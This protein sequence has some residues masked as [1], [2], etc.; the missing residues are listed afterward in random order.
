[1][2]YGSATLIKEPPHPYPIPG[3]VEAGNRI[4]YFERLCPFVQWQDIRIW[5]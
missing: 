3:P 5:I 2:S 1:M 4:D